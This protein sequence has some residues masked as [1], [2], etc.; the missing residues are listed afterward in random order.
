MEYFYDNM[1]HLVC[2]PYSI[3]NL[4][5]MAEDLGIGKHWFHKNHYDIPKGRIN[6]I[7]NRATL[8]RPREILEI[9]KQSEEIK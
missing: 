4:H 9:I 8:V 6:D 3:K 1:R 7:A 2:T 5:A